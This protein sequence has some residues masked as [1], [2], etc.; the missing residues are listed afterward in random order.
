MNIV[1]VRLSAIGD[2]TLVLPVIRAILEQLPEAKV[3]WLIGRAAYLLLKDSGH[4]R[5]TFIVTD[6]PK[7]FTDYRKLKQRLGKDYDVLLAMQAST[8]ANL[9]YPMIKAKRKIGFD[10]TRARELQWLFTNERIEFRHEHL[11]DSF[12]QFAHKLGVKTEEL[13]W[14]LALT[15]NSAGF[16][17]PAE[18]WVLNPAAS[19]LE[20]SWFAE[21][22][23]E[24]IEHCYQHYR[25]PV[26]VTGGAAE[27]ERQL[28]KEVVA[29]VSSPVINLVGKTSLQQLA[30]V[31]GNA[32]FCL[33]PDTG[34]AHIANAM[35]TP[36]IG[37]YAVASSTLSGPYLYSDLTID[38]FPQAVRELL[39]KDP[40]KVPW[41][42]RVHDRQAM[43]LIEV[44]DVIRMIAT[45]MEQNPDSQS[46]AD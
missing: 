10:K 35:N 12:C 4:P 30:A 2:C 25:L 21:H 32:T 38:R 15:E 1:V 31:L 8:R 46:V 14:Q 26:V 20:R 40:A 11:H 42:T 7:S 27:F 16:D 36:V 39:G 37:L 41:R 43:A 28:A 17:L 24:V 13:E 22:Y 44:D 19:K 45:L 5:L 6:K 18:Y 9:I 33:A 23:A 3:T 29:Q 34:P